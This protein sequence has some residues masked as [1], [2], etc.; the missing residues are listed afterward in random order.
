MVLFLRYMQF[1]SSMLKKTGYIILSV[2]LVT[3]ISGITVNMHYCGNHLYSFSINGKADSCCTNDQC[4]GCKDKSIELEIHDDFLPVLNNGLISEL[5]PL[6][7][8]ALLSSDINLLPGQ[9]TSSCDIYA[10]DISPPVIQT[11]L[12]FLQTYL[13]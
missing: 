6:Q 3:V 12:S 11:R 2:F 7:K 1:L 5:F 10:S 8:V 9:E 13:L 4:G